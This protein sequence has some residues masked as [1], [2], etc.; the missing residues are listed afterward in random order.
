M[1]TTRSGKKREFYDGT[2]SREGFGLTFP[3]SERSF[4]RRRKLSRAKG[5]GNNTILT[6]NKN[7]SP[8]IP[9]FHCLTPSLSELESVMETR[10]PR[11]LPRYTRD[12]DLVYRRRRRSFRKTESRDS[13]VDVRKDSGWTQS[14]Q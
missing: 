6:L 1:T 13:L 8:S 11:P 12:H 5:S 4:S 2:H 14:T 7:I 10:V 9:V 3:D